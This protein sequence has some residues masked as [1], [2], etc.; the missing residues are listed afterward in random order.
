MA[1]PTTSFAVLMGDLVDS[2]IYPNPAL[3]HDHFNAAIN[4]QNDEL[5]KDIVSPLT[6][7]LGDEFQGLLTSLVAAAKVARNIRYELLREEI[8]CRFV[9]GIIDLKTNL[10]SERAWNMLGPG[11]ADAREKLNEKRSSN[12]YRFSMPQEEILETMLEALGASLSA[13]E[14]DWSIAQR[15]DITRLVGGASVAEIASARNVSVHNIYKVRAAGDFDL[16]VLQWDAIH[17]ALTE[18]DRK[19]DLPEAD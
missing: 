2:E 16:Y 8:D 14:R 10:N 18:L 17:K 5:A 7:T 12:R 15:E 6:I 13:I 4:R 9:I 11:F 19:Y 1:Q 3:L